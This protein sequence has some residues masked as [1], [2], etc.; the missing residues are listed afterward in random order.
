MHK[1][2]DSVGLVWSTEKPTYQ[3]TNMKM[4]TSFVHIKRK[5]ER[6]R[7]I[8]YLGFGFA[9]LVA[10]FQMTT[11]SFCACI[12]KIRKEKKTT[13]RIQKLARRY[14]IFSLNKILHLCNNCY[15]FLTLNRNKKLKTLFCHANHLCYE[16]IR[17][18][19]ALIPVYT[20]DFTLS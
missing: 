2:T 11:F 18:Y 15:L 4:F 1:L 9:I 13:W 6:G 7:Y 20:L 8:F 19:F 17:T 16:C 10:C 14:S 5:R 12:K 3:A